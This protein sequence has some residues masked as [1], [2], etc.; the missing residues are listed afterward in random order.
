MGEAPTVLDDKGRITVSRRFRE[1]MNV[2]GHAVWYMT[3]GFDGCVFLFPK[4]NWDRIREEIKKKPLLDATAVDFRRLFFGGVAEARP[5]NQGRMSIPGYLRDYASLDKEALLLGC[6]DHLEL[7]DRQAWRD[8]QASQE[9]G[10]KQ[11][12]SALLS[13]NAEVAKGAKADSPSDED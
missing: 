7:W 1:T 5:D 10:Y 9:D 6:D 11:M 12:A 4:D 13:K 8:Y 2:M 3:R